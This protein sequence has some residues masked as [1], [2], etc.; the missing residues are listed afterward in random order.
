MFVLQLV[1][2]AATGRP[3]PAAAAALPH[4]APDAPLIGV[5]VLLGVVIL[6]VIAISR[7]G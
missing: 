7:R 5:I 3:M 1:L 4:Y 6:I 2:S